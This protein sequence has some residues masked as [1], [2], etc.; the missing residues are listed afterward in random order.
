MSFRQTFQKR[1]IRKGALC[2]KARALCVKAR[3]HWVAS[4]PHLSFN[5][6][7]ERFVEKIYQD[8]RSISFYRMTSL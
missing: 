7:G 6:R 2:V 1:Q 4:S 5:K 8:L 3:A